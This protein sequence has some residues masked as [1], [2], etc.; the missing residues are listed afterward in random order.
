METRDIKAPNCESKDFSDAF[1]KSLVK[2]EV[3]IMSEIK[4]RAGDDESEVARIKGAILGSWDEFENNERAYFEFVLSMALSR[5]RTSALL[6]E[7]G[8]L[9]QAFSALIT[10]SAYL[11]N[12]CGHDTNAIK[13]ILLVQ[14][15]RITA[16]SKRVEKF[17]CIKD[18]LGQ[19]WKNNI[20][21]GKK[22]TEAAILLERTDIYIESDTK[23]KRAVLEKYVREWQRVQ[24]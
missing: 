1:I 3:S 4:Q 19:H 5:C 8:D 10:A 2:I 14:K 11:G 18:D 6:F 9:L 21:H 24:K 17:K 22:A 20:D 12:A 15:Q 23:P 16:N 13:N 7:N